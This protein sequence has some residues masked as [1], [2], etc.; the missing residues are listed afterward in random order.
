MNL[1]DDEVKDLVYSY[2]DGEVTNELYTFGMMLLSEIQARAAQLDSKSTTMLGWATGIL[3][4]LLIATNK[5]ITAIPARFAAASGVF[6]LLAVICS[7]LALRTREDWGW[8]GDTSWLC[9]TA[10]VSGDELKRF[11]IRVIHEVRQTHLV[12]T[13]R[14]ARRLLLAESFI[15]IAAVFLFIGSIRFTF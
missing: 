14:K 9:K 6:A 3:A 5:S 7:F 4:F 11:H 13:K 12:A 2:K 15:A 1:S 10:L 8:P